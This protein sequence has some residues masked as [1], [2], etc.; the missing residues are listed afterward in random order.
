MK[1][2]FLVSTCIALSLT[3]PSTFIFAAGLTTKDHTNYPIDK[4]TESVIKQK[5]Q[6]VS[7]YDQLKAGKIPEKTYKDA[8]DS[9]NRSVSKSNTTISPSI[10]LASSGH[11][12]LYTSNYIYNL[13]QQAQINSYYCGPATVSSMLNAKSV[14]VG[15]STAASS[16]GTTTNGTDWYNGSGYPVRNT[17][18]NYLNTAWY[19]PYGTSI[20]VS[21]FISNVTFDIDNSYSVAGDAYEVVNGYHLVGHPNANIFHWFAIDGYSNSGNSTHYAD[22]VHGASSISWSGNVPAYST[23]DSSIIARIVDGRGIIW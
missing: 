22:S 13:Y 20:D 8:L 9:F 7:L 17:L 4:A 14:S 6:L 19:A 3:L 1:K 15:Q 11:I 21:T 16:L 10:A 5:E 2:L 12:P 23:M 18:N